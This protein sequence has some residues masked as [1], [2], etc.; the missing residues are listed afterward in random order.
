MTAMLE[1][2]ATR[3][4]ANRDCDEPAEY[5][6]TGFGWPERRMCEPHAWMAQKLGFQVEK[7]A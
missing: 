4:E 6:V 5:R 3:C 7:K 2:A 1:P